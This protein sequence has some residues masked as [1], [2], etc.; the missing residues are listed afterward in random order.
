M[1][2]TLQPSFL[3]KSMFKVGFKFHRIWL[4]VNRL[5]EQKYEEIK[6]KIIYKKD[7]N[8]INSAE[9]WKLA[10]DYINSIY[11]TN[12]LV[13]Q[14]I[15]EL[16]KQLKDEALSI[17][18]ISVLLWTLSIFAL[19]FLVKII[20]RMLNTFGKLVKTIEDQKRLYKAFAEFSEIL[21]YNK[22][23]QT[24]LNSLSI[25]LYKTEK[26][27]Y[28]WLGKVEGEHVEPIIS[29][30]IPTALIQKDLLNENSESLKFYKEIKRVIKEKEFV[31]TSCE[32]KINSHCKGIDTIGI[33]PIMKEDKVAFIL[34][35][36]IENSGIF[37]TGMIDL[38]TKMTNELTY[39]F[40]KIANKRNEER[41]K[42]ELRVAACA[43]DSHEAITITD[44]NGFIVK[45]NDAFTRITGYKPEDV[46]GKK[47]NVL[48][49]GI[50]DKDFYAAMWDSI[51]K[52]GH[53]T[54]EIFNRRKNGEIYPELL[55]VSTIKDK[56]GE[57]THYIAHFFD[58]SEIK[59]AQQNAEYRAQHDS[60]TDLYNRQKLIE[61]LDRIYK[62]AVKE[63]EYNAFLFFD[64]DNFKYINDYYNHE[65]GDKVLI[66]ISKRLREILYED[67]ILARIAGD[68]FALIACNLGKDKSDATKKVSILIEKIKKLFEDPLDIDGHHIEVTF[69]V[70]VK[71][72]PDQETNYK[73][74]MVNA[75]IAMYYAKKNGKNQY[76]FFNERLN[77]E[78]KQFLL[79]KNE[80]AEA[81]KNRE[82]ILHYQPKV[83]IKSGEVVGFEALV[84]W[85]HPQ[86]GLLYPD[87]FLYVTA[88]NRLS[89]DLSEYVLKEVCHQIN[90]W[91]ERWP[92]FDKK[93]SI[94][95]SGEQFNNKNFTKSIMRIIEECGTKPEYLDF[96]IVEDALLKDID[97][98]IEVIKT[99]KNIGV[100]FSMDD[101]GTG[102][103]SI[104]YLK[105]LPVDILKI[106]KS[107]I[108]DLFEGKNVEIVKMII[109]TAKVF[110]LKV[111]AEGV[112]NEKILKYLDSCG[113]DYYQGYYFSKPITVDEATNMLEKENS[114]N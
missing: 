55:S 38:I 2:I 75:D 3:S 36:A 89:F 30:N 23:E 45:V 63:K 25:M 22:D 88:G 85:Q 20:T 77:L 11:K 92:E 72:F 8:G 108:L 95:I 93:I 106:D 54:G 86:R 87:E 67:D 56:R 100:T 42:E 12:F 112:E 9:W 62:S 84:R 39:A 16:K 94:N 61:E 80:L 4:K 60:L 51:R 46:I 64:L 102:Y 71:I 83:S 65:I 76:H 19:I 7:I 5:T 96:E 21:V 48:K 107:F 110:D 35:I 103:S 28:L 10:T 47:P 37:D 98:T 82:L 1:T 101:F 68:E 99:F 14:K 104:N 33:F 74:V 58:I 97:R 40:E 41:L 59:K 31:I 49:S 13:L 44:S 79:I 6:Q 26:F 32:N 78:S 81:I 113:C 27:V 17:L 50:H 91:K 34:V 69:S 70:G 43:F 24:I 66:E 111:V 29:E 109:D 73:D 15:I 114:K 52:F 18:S 53:W 105:N 57:I 90:A